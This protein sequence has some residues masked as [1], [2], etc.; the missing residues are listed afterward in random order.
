M[1]S[2]PRARNAASQAPAPQPT[3]TTLVGASS[4]WT[5]GTMRSGERRARCSA[6]ALQALV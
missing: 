1:S 2:T 4:S 6:S 3:S 5:S